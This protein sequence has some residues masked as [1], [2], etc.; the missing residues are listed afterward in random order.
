MERGVLEQQRE[1]L[2]SVVV[3]SLHLLQDDVAR[4]FTFK[5]VATAEAVPPRPLDHA[6]YQV[7][8]RLLLGEL[9]EAEVRYHLTSSRAALQFM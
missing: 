2:A 6:T 7:H 9:R 1:Q 3:R 4:L 8:L 5:R